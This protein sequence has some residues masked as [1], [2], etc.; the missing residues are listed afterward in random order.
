MSIRKHKI[1]IT[2]ALVISIFCSCENDMSTV[3]L[4]TKKTNLP[5]ETATGIEVLYSDSAK[6]KAKLNAPI[7]NHYTTPKPYVEMPNG[8]DLKFYDDSLNVIST[9]TSNYAI[10]RES[11][12]IMEAR[13]NVVVVNKKGEKLN[14]EHLIWDQKA[15]KIYSNEFTKITTPDEILLGNRF[16]ANEDFTNYKISQVKG[17]F[18]I[19]KE[20]N[21]PGS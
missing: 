4:I 1:F 6:I 10:N 21:A 12:D 9:L 7:M 20:K 2:L 15:K 16:E 18:N 3:D 17:N 13:N 11:E 5:V 19:K 14:T 8:I